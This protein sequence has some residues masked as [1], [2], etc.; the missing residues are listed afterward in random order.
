MWWSKELPTALAG[1]RPSRYTIIGA[2]GV[3]AMAITVLFLN[4]KKY[5]GFKAGLFFLVL[6]FCIPYAGHVL[7]GFSSVSIRIGK[8]NL[9]MK[10]K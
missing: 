1:A 2:A 8:I 10:S 5:I 4:R 9:I 3:C 7:N 6:L